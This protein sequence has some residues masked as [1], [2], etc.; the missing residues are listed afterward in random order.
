MFLLHTSGKTHPLF[1][2]KKYTEATYSQKGQ[3]DSL[4][5]HVALFKVQKQLCFYGLAKPTRIG[6]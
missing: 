1:T 2:G 6:L 5:N 3:H 4:K